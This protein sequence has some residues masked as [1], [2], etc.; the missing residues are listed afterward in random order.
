MSRTYNIILAGAGIVRATCAWEFARARRGV[1]V[2]EP[3][4]IGEGATAAGMGH[5][6][7]MD[8]SEAQFA[9]TP[10]SQLLWFRFGI[11]P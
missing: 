10:Y 5:L 11:R 1:A 6:A 7:V 8:D 2:I 9:L 3:N 4:V